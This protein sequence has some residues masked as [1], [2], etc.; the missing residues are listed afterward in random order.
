MRMLPLIRNELTKI[1]SKKSS[2]VYIIII[3]LAT[4]VSGIIY[5]NVSDNNNDNWRTQ[6]QAEMTNQ[7][8]SL[9]D[10]NIPAN[11]K[12]AIQKQIKQN[13]KFLDDNVNPHAVNNWTYMNT[14][15]T[16]ITSLVTMLCVIICSA[17]VSAE[18]S[19]GTIKQ[20]LIRPHRRFKI[21][22]SK[23]IAVSIYSLLLVLIL[24]ISGYIVGLILFGNS[25]FGT[26]MVE[27]TMDGQKEVFAGSQ[28]LFKTVLYLPSLLVISAISFM[29]STLFKNQALAVG[30]GLFVLFLSS[31]AGGIIIVLADKYT[32]TKFLIF[33]H[34]ELT[35]Y[36][37]QDKILGNITLPFS[38]GVLVVYY[39]IF[40]AITFYYF[41]KR[42]I[43]F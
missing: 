36:A 34:L 33:P 6:L 3:L 29:L 41:E 2:I 16:G 35:V 30:I 31:T 14:V 22:L 1:F 40:M 7:Q 17:N 12:V 43:S 42:D 26:K 13:Q 23:Y 19:D 11:D 38:L 39:I 10:E 18:F 9:K 24:V 25:S 5:H 20:L 8:Q 27:M 32:W 37:I 28:F 15:V 4:I 21:L